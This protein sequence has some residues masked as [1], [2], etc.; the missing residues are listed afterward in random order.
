MPIIIA[1]GGKLVRI[2]KD[3]A[4]RFVPTEHYLHK[5]EDLPPPG[6]PFAKW[7]WTKETEQGCWAGHVCRR[8]DE[9]WSRR[10]LEWRPRTGKRSVGVLRHGRTTLRVAGGG[11]MRGAEDRILWRAME[12]AY[13]QQ[14][15]AASFTLDRVVVVMLWS[16][17]SCATAAVATRRQVARCLAEWEQSF[18][19]ECV[20]DLM[21]SVHRVGERP[22]DLLPSTF[23]CTTS[24]SMES[25]LRGMC[26]KNLRIHH[27]ARRTDGR[28]SRK[29]LQWRPSGK[30]DV[31]RSTRWTDDL[32]KAVGRCR[33]L[34]TEATGG[35]WGRPMSN[36]ERPMPD[37][38]MVVGPCARSARIAT[39][40]LLANPPMKQQCLHCCVSAWRP[41]YIRIPNFKSKP[42]SVEEFRPVRAI[43]A[44]VPGCHYQVVRPCARSARIATTILLANPP[45]K[46]QCFH[47][48]VSAWRGQKDV[49]D[50]FVRSAV[51]DINAAH[52]YGNV[53]YSG[54]APFHVTT[55]CRVRNQ[56][57][58][59][60]EGASMHASQY[61]SNHARKRAC[62]QAC[63]QVCKQ[64]GHAPPRTGSS[65]PHPSS[66]DCR[67]TV[68]KQSGAQRD[69]QTMGRSVRRDDDGNN[70]THVNSKEVLRSNRVRLPGTDISVPEQVAVL[71][72]D[73]ARDLR[74]GYYQHRLPEYPDAD[75]RRRVLQ[76]KQPRNQ[77]D[78]D[79]DDNYDDN[80][81]EEE[82]EDEIR[83]FSQMKET[84][85]WYAQH[86]TSTNDDRRIHPKQ[87]EGVKY[88]ARSVVC[89]VVIV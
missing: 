41:N 52:R 20:T 54:A 44:V 37:M 77:E 6:S 48:C 24:R 14:W 18:I 40:I 88:G 55:P 61:A 83:S 34:P 4:N 11:W 23:P 71:D 86:R 87:L 8:T 38:M 29:V 46:Q 12:E 10:V 26:P 47:C 33:P 2:M 74:V 49:S 25:S 64:N 72:K 65:Y 39:T 3:E 51:A 75:Q 7:R 56:C 27:I 45:V 35:I 15:T 85:E 70:S 1:T 59:A 84:R 57:E 60:S 17:D 36:S 28:W 63:N 21:R 81:D 31:G 42:L 5:G 53:L 89:L 22:R 50:I 82:T 66:A 13:V 80:D 16:I 30:R 9:R 69:V 73:A 62:K 68:G 67:K 19:L 79:N 58:H 78:Y 43:L 76:T 32:V